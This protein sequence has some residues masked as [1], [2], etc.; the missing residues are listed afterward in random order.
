MRIVLS[1]F[2]VV[3]MVGTAVAHDMFLVPEKFR[4]SKGE[5]IVM[6]IHAGDGFPESTALPLRLIDA[7]V[8]AG[9]RK[10][11]IDNIHTDL[12]RAVGNAAITESGHIIATIIS[13]PNTI[14]M[15]PDE[16]EEYLKE[17]GLHQI[18]AERA[19]AGEA[20]KDARERYGKY[21]KSILLSG[22][23]NN[24]Y[25]LVAGLPIE[26][27]PEKDPYAAKVGDALPV[28][29]LFQGKPAAGLEVKAAST[30]PGS[31]PEVIGKTDA[32]GMISV[33]LTAAG[34]WRLHTIL[35]Q[36]SPDASAE[37]ESF[38]STLTFEIP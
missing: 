11:P 18:V 26:F 3:S 16:F 24:N 35:M 13:A 29:V 38:W 6:G 23:P 10:A 4:P 36:R 5:T 28:R 7:F 37:W 8:H 34:P 25:K 32:N 17:E 19:K 31:K 30:A 15:K 14:S 33:K 2:L 22:A 12:K 27:V 1:F 9:G 21:S 20:A